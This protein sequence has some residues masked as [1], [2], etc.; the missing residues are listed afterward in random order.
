MA[1]LRRAAVA[2]SLAALLIFP[3]TAGA[4]R[5]IRIECD[6]HHLEIQVGSIDIHLRG[7]F[8]CDRGDRAD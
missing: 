7:D 5:G 3:S 8:N 2:A 1:W 6:S 4:D